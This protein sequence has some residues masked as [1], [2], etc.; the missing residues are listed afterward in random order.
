MT[1]LNYNDLDPGIR[2]TVRLLRD[3]GFETVDSGDG[4]AKPL[5]HEGVIRYPHVAMT[6]AAVDLIAKAC[7]CAVVLGPEWHVEGVYIANTGAS[8][9]MAVLFP[10]DE[11]DARAGVVPTEPPKE[12][13]LI[14]D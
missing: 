13:K 11:R 5:D 6:C 1:D 7:R 10:E 8:V 3:E 2:E 4:V 12:K 14:L 9:I